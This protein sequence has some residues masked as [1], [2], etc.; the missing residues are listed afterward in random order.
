M[1]GRDLRSDTTRQSP[2]PDTAASAATP[3][4][5]SAPAAPAGDPPVGKRRRRLV[6]AALAALA[7]L[8]GFVLAGAGH[9]LFG[10]R[11]AYDPGQGLTAPDA[12]RGGPGTPTLP[13]DRKGPT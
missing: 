12:P 2:A 4:R 5:G 9:G 6:L 3:G 7:L 10:D 1:E 11:S 13:F 8:V